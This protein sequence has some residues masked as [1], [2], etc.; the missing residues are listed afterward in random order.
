MRHHVTQRVNPRQKIFVGERPFLE[1]FSKQLGRN[2]LPGKGG[3]PKRD[4]N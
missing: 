4:N 3:R 1:R 2:L